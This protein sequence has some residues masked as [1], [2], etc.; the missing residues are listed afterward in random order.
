MCQGCRDSF[1]YKKFWN[2][3]VLCKV[4]KTY[5]VKRTLMMSQLQ[6]PCRS[7]M[8]WDSRS[9]FKCFPIFLCKSYKMF[10]FKYKNNYKKSKTI[11]EIVPFLY[12]CMTYCNYQTILTFVR[13]SYAGSFI[14][15]SYHP[16][17]CIMIIVWI[18]I[19]TLNKNVF[20]SYLYMI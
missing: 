13:T 18:Y 9:L 15:N 12:I 11:T 16:N 5:T 2:I 20:I 1:L 14:P 17:T 6:Y 19:N 8:K 10:F 4:L 3:G 7:L